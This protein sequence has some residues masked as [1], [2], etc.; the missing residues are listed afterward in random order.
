MLLEVI[1]CI[2]E[3][4]GYM[5]AIFNGGMLKEVE[6]PLDIVIFYAGYIGLRLPP[7]QGLCIP[8]K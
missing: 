1:P 5:D 8:A 6:D 2:D 7:L 4:V 3:G